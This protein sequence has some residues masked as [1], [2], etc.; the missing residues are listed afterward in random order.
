MLLILSMLILSAWAACTDQATYKVTLES[1]WCD[2]SHFPTDCPSSN[3]WSG[4]AIGAH[5]SNVTMFRVGQLASAGVQSVAETGATATLSTEWGAHK[6]AGVASDLVVETMPAKITTSTVTV[7]MCS[8]FPLVSFVSMMAPSP[9]WFI[10]VDSLNLRTS[11]GWTSESIQKL[12]VLDAGT[13]GGSSYTAPN[14]PITHVPIQALA[15][16]AP[17]SAVS[18]SNPVF[19]V[20]IRLGSAAALIPFLGFLGIILVAVM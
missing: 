1:L 17:L 2:G 14:D 11:G 5:T 19:R 8:E 18:E 15:G 10:G 16:Y 7:T 6:A 9:D 20:T 12:V 4:L 3:H 13:D